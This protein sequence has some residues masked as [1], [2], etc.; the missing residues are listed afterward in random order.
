MHT[1]RFAE[2]PAPPKAPTIQDIEIRLPTEGKPVDIRFSEKGGQLSVSVR[3]VDPQ[4]A[5]DLR[6]KLPELLSSLES[7]G[8]DAGQAHAA[9][10]SESPPPASPVA[11]A[12]FQFEHGA[13][14]PFQQQQRQQQQ[15]Q[16]E[17]AR[18]RREEDGPSEEFNLEE[19]SAA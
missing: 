9:R 17:N 5:Q 12:R 7:K 2:W 10:D 8:Y 3:A 13:G 15:Q 14:E 1:P 19:V 16:R 18:G 6:A 4:L 11:Y